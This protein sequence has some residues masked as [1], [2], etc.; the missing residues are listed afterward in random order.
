MNR[1]FHAEVCVF[2]KKIRKQTKK[3]QTKSYSTT[4]LHQHLHL[5]RLPGFAT[6]C[7][8][9]K[10]D[11]IP[12]AS[13]PWSEKFIKCII[14]EYPLIPKIINVYIV[15]VCSQGRSFFEP[16]SRTFPRVFGLRVFA[17][18]TS[19]L[20]VSD[21]WIACVAWVAW[22]AWV[23]YESEWVISSSIPKLGQTYTLGFA[24]N[25][26]PKN[27]RNFPVGV[28]EVIKVDLARISERTSQNPVKICSAIPLFQTGL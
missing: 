18:P 9:Q 27:F 6:G 24:V 7:H 1:D 4:E 16:T 17:S 3:D 14:L 28:F 5:I 25:T 21:A 12:G 13:V 8:G 15:S 20:R 26:S 19:R 10:V 11:H 22:I 23:R 2:T